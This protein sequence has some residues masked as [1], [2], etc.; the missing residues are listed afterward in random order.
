MPAERRSGTMTPW[1]PKAATERMIAP[2]LRGSVM[3]SSATNSGMPGASSRGRRRSLG[4]AYSYGGTCRARPWCTAPSV[5]RSSSPRGV[6]RIGIAAL[7]RDLQRLADAVVGVDRPATYIVVDRDLG[8]Q[9]LDDRVAPGD[10]LAGAARLLAALP[11][12]DGRP[13]AL[14]AAGTGRGCPAWPPGPRSWPPGAWSRSTALGVGPLPSRPLRRW[15]P[16]ADLGALAVL[17]LRMAPRRWELPGMAVAFQ[18]SMASGRRS[19]RRPRRRA[20]DQRAPVAVSSMAMPAA[21]SWSR[22]ASAVAKSLAAR[23]AGAL[24]RAGP[25]RGR[26]GR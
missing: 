3:P 4:C 21:V 22:M 6:S 13:G 12:P 23:A 2:R 25:T 5:S 20:S 11:R 26:R 16:R 15:P 18:A 10:D 9:R 8:A 24:P 14:P 19:R 1:P 17:G 7:G